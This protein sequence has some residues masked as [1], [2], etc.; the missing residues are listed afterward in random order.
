VLTV[1]QKETH[2]AVDR[3]LLQCADQDAN[4]MKTIILVMN[5]GATGVIWKQSPVI[6]MEDSGISEAKKGTPSLEQ[7]ESDVDSFIRSQ[8]HHSL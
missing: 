6:S 8:G 3:D 2:L 7:G 1:K 4:F 5:L